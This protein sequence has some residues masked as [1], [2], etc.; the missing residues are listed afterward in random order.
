MRFVCVFFVR[1][2]GGARGGLRTERWCRDV[3]VSV[4]CRLTESD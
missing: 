3:F 1:E 2:L 4:C